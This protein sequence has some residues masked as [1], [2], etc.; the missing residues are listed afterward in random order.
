MYNHIE[1][2][3]PG[4]IGAFLKKY[5]FVYDSDN[6]F[7]FVKLKHEEDIFCEDYDVIVSGI[8]AIVINGRLS[9]EYEYSKKYILQNRKVAKLRWSVVI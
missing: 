2:V 3:L 9:I 7:N 5:M 4:D 1:Y 6:K 8:P